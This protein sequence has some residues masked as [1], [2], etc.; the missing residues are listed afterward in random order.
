MGTLPLEGIRVI[1]L[2]HSWAAPHCARL[3]A[4]CGA[5]VIKVEYIRRLCLL[6]GAQR[7]REVYDS[8][9]GWLQVNRNKYG[10][11]LDLGDEHERKVF[12][13]L[14]KGAD[15]VVHN[16]RT[17]VPAKR[18][19]A[20]DDLVAI[21]RDIIVLSMTAFG[22][23]GPY[24]AY[25]G[26]GAV[27]E[28]IGGLQCLTAYERNGRPMRIK[29][30]DVTNGLA[31]ASAV[32]TAVLHRERT[33][34][35]QYID[36]SQLEA[37]THALIGEHLLEFALNGARTLPLGNRHR[38]FAPQGCYRCAGEDKWIT[39]TVRSEEEWERFCS[40]LGHPEWSADPRYATAAARQAH[41]DELDGAIRQW[42]MPQTAYEVMEVLQRNGIAA[43][44]VLDVEELRNDVHLAERGYFVREADEPKQYFMGMPFR[45][46]GGESRLPRRGPRLGQHNEYVRSEVLN[47]P[48]ETI[49]PIHDEDIRMAFDP[50]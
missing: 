20:Y 18:G 12:Y 17:G 2:S 14:I 27:M 40:V 34:E 32:M 10:I 38:Q 24:G 37:A 5:E 49:R 4:D 42:T 31:G 41:H 44:A 29:E 6:R 33:G 16:A 9:P 39:L 43:G 7:R 15:V 3:L 48:K 30:V 1:D 23:S 19:F 26:Y 8:H 50:E 28:G 47:L 21:K 22:T 45:L 25:A 13:A 36:L 11:T 35:G 46:S